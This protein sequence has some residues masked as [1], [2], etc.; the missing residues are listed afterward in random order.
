MLISRAFIEREQFETA[1]KKVEQQL[2][3]HVLR[4]RYDLDYDSTGD[5]AAYFKIVLPDESFAKE[6]LLEQ[7]RYVSFVIE[8]KL[9]PQRRWGINPYFRFRSSSEQE[10]MQEP[11][12]V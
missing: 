11:A 1:V 7:T 9:Q 3:P 10:R 2:R 5:P 4:I 8:Q 12:W 6:K